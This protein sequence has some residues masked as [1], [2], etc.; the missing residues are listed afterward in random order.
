MSAP[1][2][3]DER[4]EAM[5]RRLSFAEMAALQQA[6]SDP[7]SRVPRLRATDGSVELLSHWQARAALSAIPATTRD[8]V[9]EEA[10]KV[11]ESAFSDIAIPASW[12]AAG[13]SIAADVR[14]L[15]STPDD[16]QK[17]GDHAR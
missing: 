17:G 1:P 12:A 10:A 3:P 2:Q 15:K 4:I 9:L 11:A 14:A 8:E 16:L 5:A 6:I 7:G 13:D